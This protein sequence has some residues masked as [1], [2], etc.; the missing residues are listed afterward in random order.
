MN[1]VAW[2][3][4]G[5]L[6]AVLHAVPVRA[7]SLEVRVEPG[8][9]TLQADEVPLADVVRA[10][11]RRAAVHVLLDA[12]RAAQPVTV[13]LE[14]GGVQEAIVRLMREAGA[15][16][17]AILS[18]N[19]QGNVET[20]AFHEG[21]GAPGASQTTL[22]APPTRAGRRRYAVGDGSTYAPAARDQDKTDAAPALDAGD[23]DRPAAPRERHELAAEEYKEQLEITRSRLEKGAEK[24]D[25]E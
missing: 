23:P 12:Q 13:R 4:T 3:I 17:Y 1:R 18:S 6:L 25:G 16:N 15:R 9:V 20:F 14:A 2:I 10:L 22:P 21:G 8:R 5:L 24:G 7:G 19:A 11:S